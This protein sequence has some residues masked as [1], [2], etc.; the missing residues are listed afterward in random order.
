MTDLAADE[1]IP[2]LV[3]HAYAAAR[4]IGFPL[5]RDDPGHGRGSASLPGTGQFLAMLAA[6]CAG[7][8]IAELGTGAGIGSAW[9]AGAMPADCTL[10]TAEID[11]VRAE[12]AAAVL[13]GDSRVAVLT[14]DWTGLLPPL[15]PF[16]LIFSDS[17]VRDAATFSGLV[18][19]LKP[20]GRIVMDDVTP[21]LALP[22]DSPF[23]AADLKREFFAGESRL[24]WTEVVLPDLAN[25]LLVGTRK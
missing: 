9:M 5:T 1:V 3:R 10:V 8:S 23:R 4:R 17:G 24:A 11:P 13:A 7:G 20:G 12:A 6:G 14:G 16:D 15:G 18:G 25:S 21:V 22:A 19:L 2:E